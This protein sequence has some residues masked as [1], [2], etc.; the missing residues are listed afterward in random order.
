MSLLQKLQEA[1]ARI[2]TV[3]ISDLEVDTPYRMLSL[4]NV[5]TKFGP[6]TMA[7]LSKVGR[8][9][10]QEI[11]PPDEVNVYLP[12]RISNAL[13]VDDINK[14]NNDN[15]QNMFLVYHG[16]NSDNSFNMEFY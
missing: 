11:P 1:T 15:T 6:S 2:E 3:S 12:R 16:K 7:L 13:T 9:N 8:E 4:S 10:G 14:Y 5:S